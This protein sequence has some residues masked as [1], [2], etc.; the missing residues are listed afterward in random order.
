M[1]IQSYRNEIFNKQKLTIFMK[2]NNKYYKN[3]KKGF[4]LL[5][6]KNISKK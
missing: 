5:S 3:M 6:V 2:L 4:S 1:C